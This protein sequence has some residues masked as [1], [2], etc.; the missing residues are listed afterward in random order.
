MFGGNKTT[1]T[2]LELNNDLNNAPTFSDSNAMVWIR[3]GDGK[4]GKRERGSLRE[5]GKGRAGSGILK[6]ARG[7]RN[8]EPL[9]NIPLII[10]NLERAKRR[11]QTERGGKGGKKGGKG[12]KGYG[13]RDVWTN[14][15]EQ[16]YK[17]WGRISRN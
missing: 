11:K 14:T 2:N 7:G 5:V 10:Y 15:E 3:T 12:T 13:K 16:V 8:R 1:E 4:P 9:N 6:L 17:F